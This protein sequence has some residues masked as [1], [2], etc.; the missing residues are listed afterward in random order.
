MNPQTSGIND[1]P[2]RMGTHPTLALSLVPTPLDQL[3]RSWVVREEDG[4]QRETQCG[5]R[6]APHSTPPESSWEMCV[7]IWPR[8]RLSF[9]PI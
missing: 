3:A 6:P 7:T 4:A 2:P 9:G 1:Q 8:P 5:A